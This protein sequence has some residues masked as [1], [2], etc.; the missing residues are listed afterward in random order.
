MGHFEKK[1]KVATGEIP[2]DIVLKGGRI[3][4]VFT[5]EIQ[6]ADIALSG[7]YIAGLGSYEGKAILDVTNK[8][9]LPGF[10]DGHIHLESTM[11]APYELSK[12]LIKNGTTTVIADPHEIAN[13]LGEDGI[14]F[15][16]EQTE[17]LP[18]D[19]YFMLPS[20]VPATCM[21]TAGA[22]L[23]AADLLKF[24]SH[25][26][27]LG[28]AEM[29]NSAGVLS[30]DQDIISKILLFKDTVLDG[31]APSLS[32]KDLNAYVSCGIRSDHECTQTSE[33]LEK[34]RLG[35]H[36]MIRE[37][38]QAKN[39]KTL[40]PVGNSST[41]MQCSLVTDDLHPH[42]L[43]IKGHMN[44]LINRAV[45]EGIDSISAIV[46]AT[47]STARYFGLRNVGAISPG[48]IGD[49]VVLSSLDPVCIETVIKKGVV[50]YSDG[51]LRD[52]RMSLPSPILF[53]NTM[54]IKSYDTGS[55]RIQ[56]Q[57]DFI[58][59]I[60]VVPDQLLTIQEHLRT[61][62][63]EGNVISD[64]DL[65]LLKLAVLERHRESGN[66]GIGMVQGFG[67]RKGALATSVA[68][69]SHNVICVGCT[70]DDM[71]TAVKCIEDM[72]GGLAV[73]ADGRVLAKLALP[74]AGLLSDLPLAEVA[75]ISESL[76]QAAHELGCQLKE[77]FMALSFLA[78][79]VIPELKIT[80]MGL[81][82]VQSFHHVPLFI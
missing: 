52:Q 61:P 30:A 20:C 8:Y 45:S 79:P 32:G 53:E 9:V 67:M 78:L 2:A 72:G 54:H 44:Y 47:L 49:I 77:P 51:E 6:N 10:I 48:Y 5:R 24:K 75:E 28:L 43:L 40:A 76:R 56:S 81:F 66:I 74:L 57:G 17:G 23:T 63:H 33:A 60:R 22:K 3:I 26:R 14:R 37:G 35:M 7:E 36:L 19:F 73:V 69:D 34:L 11:L 12:A 29:M 82:D 16:L 18:V 38:T 46:M 71:Y 59:T 62:V 42:D 41:A 21:E 25:P 68:H 64:P 27:V 70:D 15:Y 4:N 13:V 55:F 80:D 39:L 1:I 58:R 65:D 31:H 50:V